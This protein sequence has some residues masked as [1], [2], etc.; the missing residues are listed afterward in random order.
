MT[1][2]E[3]IAFYGTQ[4]GAADA[5]GVTQP[6]VAEW[7]T[8]GIPLPRQAQYELD[9]D[10]KLVAERPARADAPAEVRAS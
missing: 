7:K 3:L 1:Y 10:G 2:D 5:I 8:G 6:S 9:S 4:K